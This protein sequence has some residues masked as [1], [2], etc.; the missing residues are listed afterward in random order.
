[1]TTFEAPL[2]A[3][4]SSANARLAFAGKTADPR[5]NPPME[6]RFGAAGAAVTVGVGL[7][8]TVSVGAGEGIGA[9][10]SGTLAE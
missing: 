9:G 5:A 7:G 2:T 8:D 6:I 1:M 10:A 4:A 3:E